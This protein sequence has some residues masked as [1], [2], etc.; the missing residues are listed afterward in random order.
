ME[1]QRKFAY[2]QLQ[3]KYLLNKRNAM[4][5]VG[6][7]FYRQE[8]GQEGIV[9]AQ[10]VSEEEIDNTQF[11][12]QSLL[13]KSHSEQTLELFFMYTCF[14]LNAVSMAL[15][16]IDQTSSKIALQIHSLKCLFVT[17]IE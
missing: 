10:K 17:D 4:S 8:E 13:L 6:I 1:E 15:E 11:S 2:S 7:N 5:L 14:V 3:A 12:V 16:D 9:Y